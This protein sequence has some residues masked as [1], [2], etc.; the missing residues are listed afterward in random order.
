MSA[1]LSIIIPTRNAAPVIGPTL[2]A[3]TEGLGE[4]LVQ[5]LILSDGGSEDDIAEVAEAVGARLVTGAPGRG[6]QLVRGIAAARGAWLLVLHA[7]SVPAPGWA[8]AVRAHLADH[9][10]QAGYFD[11]R[12]D[13]ARWAA[14]WT[15]GWANLRARVLGLPYGDQGLLIARSLYDRM[16]GYP[17][18]PLMEDVALADRLGRRHLR[19]LG[20]Q[21][22]TSSARYEAAGWWR[23]GA[24]NLST[25]ALYRM[26]RDPVALSRR[27]RR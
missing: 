16:G 3:L 17:E 14:R 13:S 1:P 15:A 11:L 18:I 5:E 26:G 20:H 22:T 2:A 4:G 7:D 21:I 23:R 12:F 25:L 8:A 24:R 6:G 19:P 10:E 9:P 27:Y